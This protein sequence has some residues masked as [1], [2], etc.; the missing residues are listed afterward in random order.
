MFEEY[1]QCHLALPLVSPKRKSVDASVGLIQAYHERLPLTSVQNF[2]M[3][4]LT[5]PG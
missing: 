3:S 4:I 1:C 2:S 5:K